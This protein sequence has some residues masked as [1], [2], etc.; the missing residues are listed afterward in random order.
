MIRRIGKS[1]QDPG[2]RGLRYLRLPITC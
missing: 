1:R 2:R